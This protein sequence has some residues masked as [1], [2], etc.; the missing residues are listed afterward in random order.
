MNAFLLKLLDLFKVLFIRVGVDFEQLRAIVEVKLMMDNRRQ[1]VSYQRKGKTESSNAFLMTLFFYA[2]FGGFVALAIYGIPSFVLGMIVFYSYIMVMIIMTLITDFSSILLDTSDNTIILPRPVDGRT[3]FVARLMHILLYLGQ[4]AFGLSI[5]PIIVVIIKYGAV[6]AVAF[7]VGIILSALTAVS[8]TNAFYLLLMQFAS[9]EKLKNIINYFQIVMAVFIMGGYQILPRMMERLDIE[10]YVFEIHWWN[11]LI[12]PIWM[13]GALETIH[14]RQLDLLHLG[15][16]TIAVVLPIAGTYLVNKYLSPVFSRKLG[17]LSG[18]VEQTETPRTEKGTLI[19]RISGWISRSAIERGAFDLIFRILGRDRKIKL[20]IYPAF[21]YIIIFGFI[22]MMRGKEDLATTWAN[23]PN[24]QYHLLLIYLTFM[25][26]QTALHEIPYSDDFKASWIYF[27]A[28]L[29]RPGEI[30][31]G[32]L[33]AMFVRL[34]IPGYTIIATFVL[35]VWGFSAVDDLIFGIFN[36]MIM[37]WIFALINRRYLPFSLEPNLRAQAGNFVRNILSFLI[38][39]LLGLAHYL[40][41]MKSYLIVATIP[42]QLMA[43]YWL[44][45]TYKKTS[46]NDL[47][48]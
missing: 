13:A 34:F 47:S 5:I 18:G 15:L 25:I 17:A 2:I 31:S 30:L 22:F 36:N 27:S 12:P 28:P 23:L 43:I 32:T 37:L 16:I 21:G 33:K 39:G 7:F 8:L 45:Q 1:I 46:W 48:L 14:L 44:H 3:L 42:L 9:E 4:L 20:K 19:E 29:E 41:A 24:S 40:L 38:I 35:A 10:N 6:M 11:F 26:L